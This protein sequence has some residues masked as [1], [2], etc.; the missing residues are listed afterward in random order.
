MTA[1]QI[2]TIV[3]LIIIGALLI[4]FLTPSFIF[5]SEGLGEFIIECAESLKDRFVET[6][7]EWKYIFKRWT[8]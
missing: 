1:E 4:F 6:T 5:L 2:I 7:N 8:K 3:F